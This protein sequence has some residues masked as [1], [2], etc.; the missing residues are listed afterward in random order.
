QAGTTYL[1][2]EGPAGLFLIDQHAAHERVMYERIRAGREARRP[3]SQ[4]LL[5][6]VALE[7]GPAQAALVETLADD[8]AR[9]RLQDKPFGPRGRR[10]SRELSSAVLTRPP[11]GQ[12]PCVVILSR[13]GCSEGVGMAKNLASR[14]GFQRFF[15]ESSASSLPPLLPARVAVK[16]QLD[17]RHT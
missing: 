4:S 12:R 3:D 6:P 1:I 9:H 17:V 16:K 8:L 15:S 11:Q 14:S 7:L 13:V 5:T 2:A 10:L